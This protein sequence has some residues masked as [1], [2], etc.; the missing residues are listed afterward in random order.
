MS[1]IR[2]MRRVLIMVLSVFVTDVVYIVLLLAEFLRRDVCCVNVSLFGVLRIF[3]AGYFVPTL[4]VA[5]Q[6]VG[7]INMGV[8]EAF[9]TRFKFISDVLETRKRRFHVSW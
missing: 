1:G 7:W 9:Q 5:L 3:Y 6:C 8:N 2:A 4:F